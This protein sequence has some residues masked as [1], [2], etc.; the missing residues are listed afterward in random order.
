MPTTLRK[1]KSWKMNTC[2]WRVK[3]Q[4]QEPKRRCA[5]KATAAVS[6]MTLTE[7]CCR[8]SRMDAHPRLP[9]WNHYAWLNIPRSGLRI[10]PGSTLLSLWS[11]RKKDK[12]A[13]TIRVPSLLLF[14]SCWVW[15]RDISCQLW[16]AGAQFHGWTY[17]FS[18]CRPGW[19]YATDEFRAVTCA[20]LH[21]QMQW[22]IWDNRAVDRLVKYFQG[23]TEDK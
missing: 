22:R 15:I 5:V 20:Q 9:W 16:E 17:S 19:S 11:L 6:V 14:K 8:F 18:D 12:H 23:F 3:R 2:Q 21:V 4:N 13:V 10:K 1:T 7:V